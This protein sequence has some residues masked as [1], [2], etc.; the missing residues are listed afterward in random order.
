M[1]AAN[2][3]VNVVA[4]V[5]EVEELLLLSVLLV[6]IGEQELGL[7]EVL[8]ERCGRKFQQHIAQLHAVSIWLRLPPLTKSSVVKGQA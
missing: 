8:G 2:A 3:A 6:V 1:P 7:L 5:H 4:P